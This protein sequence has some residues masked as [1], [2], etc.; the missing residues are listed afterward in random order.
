MRPLLIILIFLVSTFSFSQNLT[1]KYLHFKTD[2]Y[3]DTTLYKSEK[4]YYFENNN[5]Q[6]TQKEYPVLGYLFTIIISEI[7]LVTKD[8]FERRE[9]SNHPY[10][11]IMKR[12]S[13]FLQYSDVRRRKLKL[14]KEYS[15]SHSD[16]VNSLAEKHSLDS[17]YGISVSGFSTYLGVAKVEINGKQFNT[18]RFLEDH[19]ES[20]SHPSYFTKE[21]FLD[22]ATQS[23]NPTL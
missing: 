13:I 12:N 10:K 11:Y 21:V 3:W 20:S 16:T 22:Q 14:H 17:K 4:V 19:Y 7:P 8:S 18:F 1:Y 2:Y 23:Q 5:S 6:I 9:G 15:L